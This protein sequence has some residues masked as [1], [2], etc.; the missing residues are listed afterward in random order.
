[1]R[2]SI[3]PTVVHSSSCSVTA[4][5]VAVLCLGLVLTPPA[6]PVH[7][8]VGGRHFVPDQLPQQDPHLRY[9]QG[10]EFFL[11]PLLRLF[12]CGSLRTACARTTLR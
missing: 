1:M 8:K 6:A 9:G 11:P 12:L 10:N 2:I 5:V 4:S 7:N 3:S